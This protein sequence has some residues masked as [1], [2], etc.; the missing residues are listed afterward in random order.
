[1]NSLFDHLLLCFKQ[2]PEQ[3]SND[4]DQQNQKGR[5][6]FESFNRTAISDL[7]NQ[8]DQDE[9]EVE[10]SVLDILMFAIEKNFFNTIAGELYYARFVQFS[11]CFP[12]LIWK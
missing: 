7:I 3:C 5:E 9:G 4:G 6:E 2:T 10:I 12:V 11:L 8:D 1:M